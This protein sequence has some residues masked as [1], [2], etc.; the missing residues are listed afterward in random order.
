MM[1]PVPLAMAINGSKD[2]VA[3]LAIQIVHTSCALTFARLHLKHIHLNCLLLRAFLY[4]YILLL[5][6]A[7]G[8]F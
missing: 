4:K 6:E 1:A 8:R 3:R 2:W 7:P 5:L